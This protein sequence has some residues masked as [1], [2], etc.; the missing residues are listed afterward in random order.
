MGRLTDKPEGDINPKEFI[1]ALN[2]RIKEYENFIKNNEEI[3]L[4]IKKA[5]KSDNITLQEMKE[6]ESKEFWTKH[7]ISNAQKK[8]SVVKEIIKELNWSINFN[9]KED[10]DE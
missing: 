8:L 6:Y 3:L 7:H 2:S 4:N 9:R 10:K 5:Q 1:K